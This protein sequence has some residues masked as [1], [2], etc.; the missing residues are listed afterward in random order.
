MIDET[1]AAGQGLTPRPVPPDWLGR[2]ARGSIL[3]LGGAAV[4]A[5][6]N[7]VLA[8]V[9]TRGLPKT[10]VGVF[11]SSTSLFL[12]VAGLG[13][14]GTSTGLVYFLSRAKAQGKLQYARAYMRTAMTPVLGIAMLTAGVFL[15]LAEP[16]AS[17]MSRSHADLFATYLRILSLFIPLVAVVNLST[18]ATRGMGT[19]RPSAFLDHMARPTLQLGLVTFAVY[20]L[21]PGLVGWAWAAPYLP[22]ALLSW[23]A[24]H[25]MSTGYTGVVDRRENPSS[26]TFWRFTAPRAVAS[27][28]QLAMQRLD[29]ILVGALAGFTEAAIYTA[30]TRF[31]ALGQLAAGAISRAVQ[32]NLGEALAHDN[33]TASSNLYM[34]S[35]AWLVTLTW[36]LYLL[37]LMFASTILET[38]GQGYSQGA[39]ALVILSLSMLV[40]TGCGMVDMVLMMAGRT[41]WNLYN[42]LVAFAVNLGLDLWLIPEIGI[43][44]AA[45][46]WGAA[47]LAKNT[48]PLVQILVSLR[49]HPFG[50]A[51]GI[52]MALALVCFG[53]VPAIARFTIG[54][55]WLG[56]CASIGVSLAAYL[57][58]LWRFRD[59][60]QLHVLFAMRRP[61]KP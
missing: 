42:V 50:A 19:M 47:I 21:P 27:V 33:R 22:I 31:L 24:W 11:F 18:S 39:E 6:A 25:R 49:L 14:L 29:I 28:A 55:N 7:F 61:N 45:I 56:L 52:A 51:S 12:L 3:N 15:I 1:R 44:G 9:I 60:L 36:P 17:F 53:V 57:L 4:S 8:V 54:P 10:D 46:G 13:Q 32:P 59:S 26:L 58:G 5:V 2:T 40:A 20:L 30:A 48:L 41:S 23:L 37:L 38:F 16:L 43:L 35:T 34:S